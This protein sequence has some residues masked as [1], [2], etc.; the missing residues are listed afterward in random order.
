MPTLLVEVV[1]VAYEGMETQE[2]HNSRMVSWLQTH[3]GMLG[4]VAMH[5]KASLPEQE[6]WNIV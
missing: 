1:L 6:V 4:Q 5:S 3:M 2:S